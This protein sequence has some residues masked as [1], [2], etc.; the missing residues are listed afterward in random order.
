MNLDTCTPQQR[1]CIEDLHAPLIICAGAGSGKTF[2][3]TRRVVNALLPQ[4]KTGDAPLLDD[5][6]QA[7]IITFTNKAAGEL[8]SR[9][10]STLRSEQLIDQALKTDDAWIST[11]HGACTRILRAHALEIGIDPSFTIAMG[12]DQDAYIAQAIDVT[13]QEVRNGT[14]TQ[15]YRRLFDL[16][17]T[18]RV[19]N[20]VRALLNSTSSLPQGINSLNMGPQPM[21]ATAIAC[22]LIP[23]CEDALTC[24]KPTS[25]GAQHTSQLLDDLQTFTEATAD[26]TTLDTLCAILESAK[27]PTGKADAVQH[28]AGMIYDAKR[29]LNQTRSYP[30]LKAIVSF[31]QCTDEHY[32]SLLHEQGALDASE[33]IRLTLQTFDTYPSIAQQ[34]TN[35]FKLVMV[36]EFQDTSQLQIDMIKR[37]AGNNCIHLCTVGDA[38]QSIYRF[39]GADVN[40]YLRHKQDMTSPQIGAHHIELKDNFRSHEDILSFVRCICGQEGYFDEPF[41]DLHAQPSAE[42]EAKGCHY[43]GTQPRITVTVT[44]AQS[45]EDAIT[46]QATAI[47]QQFASWRKAGHAPS[48]MVILLGKMSHAHVYADALN[49]VGLNCTLSGGA[50]FNTAPETELSL[51]LLRVIANP[52]ESEAALEILTSDVLPISSDDLLQLATKTDDVSGRKLAQHLGNGLVDLDAQP[53]HPS[54]LLVHAM[55]VLHRAWNRIGHDAPSTIFDTAIAESGWL[56][57][58]EQQGVRGQAQAANVL[59]FQQMIAQIEQTPG[60]DI[61]QVV[62]DMSAALD[63]KEKAGTLSID[64]N[65]AV[66]IMTVHAS[67][68]LE[69]PL[70]AVAECFARTS[71]RNPLHTLSDKGTEYVTLSLP[72]DQSFSVSSKKTNQRLIQDPANAAN[73]LEFQSAIRSTDTDRDLAERRRLFYVAA[74]RA[75]EA[76]YIAINERSSAR[77][78]NGVDGQLLSGL[79]PGEDEFPHDTRMVEYGGTQPLCYTW[80]D[81]TPT[82]EPAI[83]EI[84]DTTCL[85]S[86]HVETGSV[87]QPI[88][89]TIPQLDTPPVIDLQTIAYQPDFFSYSSL[90]HDHAE[91]TENADDEDTATINDHERATALA[92]GSDHEHDSVSTNPRGNDFDNK[93]PDN[94]S[95]NITLAAASSSS[96]EEILGDTISAI[97]SDDPDCATTFG[98]AVHRACEWVA[99]HDAP[100]SDQECRQ[101]SMYCAQRYD[102]KQEERLT[103]ALIRWTHSSLCADVLAMGTHRPEVPF[104]MS[105]G[106]G[107]LQGAI[108]LLCASDDAHVHI[109]DYKTG[110]SPDESKE[111]LHIKHLLQSQCYALVALE[112]GYQQVDMDFVRLEQQDSNDPTQPQR[113]TY[114]YDQSDY[115]TLLQHI[116]ELYQTD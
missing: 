100:P 56:H 57:R 96:D 44:A 13:L 71:S 112:Y 41:L 14:D 102:L 29:M 35:K 9:I 65:D 82:D 84:D 61:A 101:Y 20:M 87:D 31:A 40:V 18:D 80:I 113:V 19:I 93:M 43:Y 98:S 34:Y 32:R 81:A 99:Y 115:D 90:A 4:P 3:L 30:L 26:S 63:Q 114:H 28:L 107:Y 67:K 25:K 72:S 62:Y 52:Y 8:R 15:T 36:D 68:G 42:R 91:L 109:V 24:M 49:A 38:Q 47:A 116:T 33:L 2:T 76:L 50:G 86:D 22:A 16:Y 69:F 11:I 70:V 55:D 27:A 58:L 1:Q 23:A 10:R 46:S 12:A 103:T 53:Q 104:C 66:R 78:F 37:V 60:Y 59:K 110:G 95:R 85:S 97:R 54:P 77:S 75:S 48:E 111:E 17:G 92:N 5:I 64:T 106:N 74:T 45:S 51:A 105:V 39:Q 21:D 89:V 94:V 88:E 7:L 83:D 73:A 79:F 108:D 6:D